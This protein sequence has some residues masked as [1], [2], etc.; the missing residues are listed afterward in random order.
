MTMKVSIALCAFAW[1]SVA[2]LGCSRSEAPT[3]PPAP[4]ATASPDEANARVRAELEKAT[5]ELQIDETVK[6]LPAA[7]ESPAGMSEKDMAEARK[8]I[9]GMLENVRKELEQKSAELGK[10]VDPNAPTAPADPA[11]PSPSASRP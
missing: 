5:Q 7:G 6:Q 11:A 3:P 4:A 9:E 8:A 2:P 10:P 1:V